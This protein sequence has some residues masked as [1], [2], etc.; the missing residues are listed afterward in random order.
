MTEPKYVYP[1]CH[2]VA[3][4]PDAPR[5]KV[6]LHPEHPWPADDPFVLAKPQFFNVEA[7][8]VARST[9]AEP[10]VERGTR[11]PGERRVTRRGPGRPPK[12]PPADG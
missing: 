6:Q 1:N 7:L 10:P 12:N 11:A 2:A 5:G 8:N 9:P 4:W 3:Y